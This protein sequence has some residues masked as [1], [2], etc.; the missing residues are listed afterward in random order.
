M[1]IRDS[2]IHPS[3]HPIIHPFLHPSQTKFFKCCS[4]FD[5]KFASSLTYDSALP[6]IDGLVVYPAITPEIITGLKKELRS[7]LA[8]AEQLA[9]SSVKDIL[10]YHFDF[11]DKRPTFFLAVCC[12][13]LVQPSSAAAERV[14]SRLKSLWNDAQQSTM[15]DKIKIGL[16]GSFNRRPL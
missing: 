11:K 14:F 6:L 3:I 7:Y 2:S 12:C 10:G 15:S 4:L 1:C 9:A 8:T 5:P 16:M 13:V